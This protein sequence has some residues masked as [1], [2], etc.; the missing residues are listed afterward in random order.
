MPRGV[1]PRKKKSRKLKATSNVNPR[2]NAVTALGGE[3]HNLIARVAALELRMDPPPKSYT[4]YVNV[5]RD[6]VHGPYYT[7]EDADE[8]A[9]KGTR[10][11]RVKISFAYKEGQFDG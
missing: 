8:S 7:A 5:Y 3:V 4:G 11:A 9:D 1:Y 2:Q 10:L 6:T